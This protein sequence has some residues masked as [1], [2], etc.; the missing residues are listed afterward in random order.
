MRV[1][2]CRPPRPAPPLPSH[3][4][5]LPSTRAVSSSHND[6]APAPPPLNSALA[7][8][9]VSPFD[10][11]ALGLSDASLAALAAG[12]LQGKRRVSVKAVAAAAGVPRASALAWF[13]RVDALPDAA[14]AS[15]L[16][17][18]V[19]AADAAAVLEESAAAK[20]GRVA[21]AAAAAAGPPADW[22]PPPSVDRL[23]AS[24][25]ATLDRVADELGAWPDDAVL[26]DLWTLHRV[27]RAVALEFFKSRRRAAAA[28]RGRG[29]RG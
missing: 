22:R 24:A 19:A 21:A 14:R 12:Y 28:E 6:W 13:K 7:S 29:K 1:A 16:A 20:R 26:S 25:R 8:P 17:A 3:S 23:S 9:H 15:A 4:A 27:P 11:S 2:A 18:L 10:A 5:R